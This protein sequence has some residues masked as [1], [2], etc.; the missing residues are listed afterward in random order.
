MSKRLAIFGGSFNPP[1]NSHIE[2]INIL[3]DEYDLVLILPAHNHRQKSYTVD[4]KHRIN[5]LNLS[6]GT[7]GADNVLVSDIEKHNADGSTYSLLTDIVSVEYPEYEI[8]V[9]IGEDN[10]KNIKTWKNCDLLLEKYNFITFGRNTNDVDSDDWY[11]QGKHSYIKYDNC[12]SSSY[13]RS[14]SDSSV[15]TKAVY[16]YIH[17]NKIY[18]VSDGML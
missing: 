1:T 14:T 9:V 12:I 7:I 17:L 11:K 4:I 6:I 5:M 10:A 18:G 8:T 13:Y 3:K 16:G 15:I 2:I